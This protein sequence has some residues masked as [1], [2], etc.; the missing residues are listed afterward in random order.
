LDDKGAT[1]GVF[2]TT[3]RFSS[4]ARECVER[5]TNKRIVLID[6]DKLAQLMVDHGVGVT[7]VA[8]YPVQKVD[9][10]YFEGAE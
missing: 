5:T 8:T 7:T 4:E 9:T 10:D 1:K 6:G 3:S 2:I